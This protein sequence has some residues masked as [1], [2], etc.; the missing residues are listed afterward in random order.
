MVSNKPRAARKRKRKARQTPP[1]LAEARKIT[2][3]KERLPIDSEIKALRDRNWLRKK[4][5]IDPTHYARAALVEAV[6][7]G[8]AYDAAIKSQAQALD[9]WKAGAECAKRATKALQRMTKSFTEGDLWTLAAKRSPSL[10]PAQGRKEARRIRETLMEAREQAQLI[11]D[12]TK[13]MAQGVAK[14]K[15]NPGDPFLRGFVLEMMKTWWLLTGRKPSS[16]RSDEDNPFAEFA[17]AALQSVWPERRDESSCV[18]VVTAVLPKFRQRH[19]N[20]EFESELNKLTG[21]SEVDD[22]IHC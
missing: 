14:L 6:A 17:N 13:G 21:R 10:S 2:A 15:T 3:T 7:R 16:K 20:D 9:E 22:K 12:Q 11:A 5:T 19:D 8:R 1:T 4:L 18:G